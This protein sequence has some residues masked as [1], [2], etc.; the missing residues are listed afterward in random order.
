[1]LPLEL[2]A[3][4]QTVLPGLVCFKKHPRLP[5]YGLCT[6]QPWACLFY[7]TD[8]CA[9]GRICSTRANAAPKDASV[10]QQ[11]VLSPEVTGLQELV[12]HLDMSVH[13]SLCCTSSS[14][15]AS[16]VLHLD[17]SVYKSLWCT[18]MFAVVLHLDVR[19]CAVPVVRFCL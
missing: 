3:L 10:Q 13:K 16:F 11:P 19:A 18:W 7:K 14:S 2:S 4:Q 9:H 12:L 17:V 15:S 8:F 6:V 1:V 5:L